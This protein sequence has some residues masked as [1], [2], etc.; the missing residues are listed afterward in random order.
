[1]GGL[2]GN[3][4]LPLRNFLRKDLK[5]HG[6]WMYNRDDIRLLVKIIEIGILSLEESGN[7]AGVHP[8]SRF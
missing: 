3:V 5:L 4:T 8:Q 6:K 7:N 1:M 2:L